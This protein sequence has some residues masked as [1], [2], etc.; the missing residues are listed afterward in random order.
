MSCGVGCR[1]GCD[2]ASLWLW[3]KPAATVQIRP[4]AWEPL[5][6]TGVAKEMEKN[7]HKKIKKLKLNEMHNMPQDL[8]LYLN[9]TTINYHMCSSP[10]DYQEPFLA[11]THAQG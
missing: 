5:Y 7:T 10:S 1:R 4:L 8:L 9:L 3:C 11:C 2:P 6:A